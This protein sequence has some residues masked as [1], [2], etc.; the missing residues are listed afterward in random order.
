[1]RGKRGFLCKFFSGGKMNEI[2][3]YE[4]KNEAIRELNFEHIVIEGI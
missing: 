2:E 4:N 1:M 3:I